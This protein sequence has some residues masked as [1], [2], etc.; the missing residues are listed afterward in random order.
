MFT[1]TSNVF[2]VHYFWVSEDYDYLISPFQWLSLLLPN[3][4]SNLLHR[5]EVLERIAN[6]L[7]LFLVL[8]EIYTY[9]SPFQRTFHRTLM[10]G[11]T[12]KGFQGQINLK[13]NILSRVKLIL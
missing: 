10:Y 6:I 11:Y 5:E 1:I 3:S 2:P 13:N 7:V 4:F 12:N 8:I 9:H